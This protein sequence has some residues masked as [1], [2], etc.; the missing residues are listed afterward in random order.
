VAGERLKDLRVLRGLTQ[1]QLA[2][3]SGVPV[4]TLRDYE[5]GKRNPL[6]SNAQK[7][8]KALRVSVAAF[9]PDSALTGEVE[10]T[11]KSR[12]RKK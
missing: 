11:E 4:G 1:V 6:L 7:L 2:D 3:A 12:K 5:Q 10:E 9:D 8:S